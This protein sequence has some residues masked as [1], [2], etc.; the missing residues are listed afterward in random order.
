MTFVPSQPPGASPDQSGLDAILVEM[1]FLAD[2]DRKE[3]I[4]LLRDESVLQDLPGGHLLYQ[5]EDEAE[6][7]YF[8][9]QGQVRITRTMAGPQGRPVTVVDRL[10]GPKRLV[11]VLALLMNRRHTDQAVTEGPCTLVR[12]AVVALERL[13][14]RHPEIRSQL[15]SPQTLNR[16]RTFPVM[17][18]L[19]PILLSYLA[20]EV[21]VRELQANQQV[22]TPRMEA[23]EVYLIHQG[24]VDLHSP[25]D[26]RQKVWLSTGWAFGAP[27]EAVAGMHATRWCWAEATTETTL[28][29]LPWSSVSQ[30]AQGYP[31][32]LQRII[33]DIPGITGQETRPVLEQFPLFEPLEERYRLW[34]LGF[35]SYHH[36][37]QHHL[38][39]LQ[40]DLGDSMWLLAEGSQARLSSLDEK[41]RAR[42]ES[43]A[44]GPLRFSEECLIRPSPIPT[45]V[46]AEPGS[47]W[48]Q[49]HWQD[50]RA[51]LEQVEKTEGRNARAHIEETIQRLVVADAKAPPPEK[52]RR[53]PWLGEREYIIEMRRRHW[54]ALLQKLSAALV[55]GI[56]LLLLTLAISFTR[57]QAVLL[58]LAIGGV[59]LL[60]VL[61][62][63]IVDYLNDFLIVTNQR[64]IQQE[65]VVLTSEFLRTALLEQIENIDVV[66]NFWGNLLGYGV[67]TVYTASK[68]APIRF[69]YVARPQDLRDLIRR[70][71]EMR[72]ARYRAEKRQDIQNALEQRLG[73]VVELP[74]RVLPRE[75]PKA[76][77]AGQPWWR[78]LW[79]ALIMGSA[80]RA[81]A[82]ERQVWHKHWL[83]LLGQILIP[84]ILLVLTL[85]MMILGIGLARVIPEVWPGELLGALVSLAL[86]AWMAW[87]YVDWRN[88]TYEVTAR[89]IIDI[90]KKP[91]FFAEERREAPL[92]QIQ[93][94]EV[95]MRGPV[96]ILLNFGHVRVRTA[97]TD[98]LFT[99]DYVP[100]P[101]GVKDEIHRRLEEW[102]RREE[103]RKTQEQMEHL[104]DWFEMYHRL[105]ANK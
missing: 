65:K 47:F 63:G 80:I 48:L 55:L 1:P 19:D 100:D 102:R 21:E 5:Q 34:L 9:V 11:G 4:K 14:Y 58:T 45:T 71:R 94:I 91:L 104:P 43:L 50:Y 2:V 22:F 40:G 10:E 97:A 86:L 12:I 76:Q 67:L 31:A 20:Q 98:G 84:F 32:M 66:E 87:I 3:I 89:R 30:A 28:Y 72:R 51:F 56:L 26:P 70:Q 90:E 35:C 23:K 83:I 79:N 101:Q 73:L 57:P 54:V 17:A 96:Q 33:R 27:R 82:D 25:K 103:K 74:S 69:D 16:L 77:A 44:V 38:V 52:Q 15:L 36:I 13:L 37:P 92:E 41:G 62:W 75:E 60:P 99:F 81:G 85:T 61:I 95:T 7:V 64:I 93:D 6:H 68:G 29:Q 24:Q 78:R 8:V 18:G 49:L 59:I 39:M 53:E 42:P 46:Q 88:D 105:E